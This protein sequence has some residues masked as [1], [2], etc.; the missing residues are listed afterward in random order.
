VKQ[1]HEVAADINAERVE[2][3]EREA[4]DT[5]QRARVEQSESIER[6]VAAM[7]RSIVPI[8]APA[9]DMSDDMITFMTGRRVGKTELFVRMQLVMAALCPNTINPIIYPT[10]VSAKDTAWKPLLRAKKEYFPDAKVRGDSIEIRPHS[11]D[12][13]DAGQVRV[14]G[15]ET[16]GDIG[17]WFGKP[18]GKA[19]VDECG[20]FASH[21]VDLI[22]DGLEPGMMD[23][24]GRI[25]AH[26][27]GGE[28]P[29]IWLG[30]NPGVVL[31]GLWYELTNPNRESDVPLFTGTCH[32]NPY[33]KNPQEY[34]DRLM[35]RWRWTKDTP[36]FRR[37]YLG[38]WCEDE[39]AIVYPVSAERNLVTFEWDERAQRVALPTI[40]PQGYPVPIEAWRFG[41]GVDV[42]MV[43]LTTFVVHASHP[44][45]FD[46]FI[47][48]AEGHSGLL[49]DEKA[50]V[51]ERLVRSFPKATIVIDPGGG[52]RHLIDY[53]RRR[54]SIAARVA[55][56]PHKI[57]A[58]RESRDGLLSGWIKIVDAECTKPL[59]DELR[60]LGW[61]E[62]REKHNPNQADHFADAMLYIV[63][64][65]G[66]Y[67]TDPTKF[68]KKLSTQ[69][70]EG[71]EQWMKEQIEKAARDLERR[72]RPRGRGPRRR[73]DE[74]WYR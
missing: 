10:I 3:R 1:P 52:G 58:I 30:G 73:T 20:N 33:L 55:Y 64:Y 57:A 7:R 4:A 6:I 19:I 13:E 8:F 38:E 60:H 27:P 11:G 68:A 49:D 12:W 63:R 48:H 72:Q 29:V 67:R 35:K 18:Y 31:E 51:L 47:L 23:Y 14:G 53:L 44:A 74:R 50:E 9:W 42:G 37:M 5:E 54:K 15:C 26:A 41:I 43:D 71:R 40:N 46:E 21:L 61:D 25:P 39:G 2:R 45:L 16:A 69:T 36:T 28:N 22:G 17:K 59:R 62:K 24:Q 34:L 56:K 65:A 66:H 32:D 70:Q